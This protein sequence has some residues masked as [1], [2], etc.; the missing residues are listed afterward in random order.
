MLTLE[1]KSENSDHV[2]YYGDGHRL[3]KMSF[4][5]ATNETELPYI[6]TAN[7]SIHKG[8]KL[9]YCESN[10]FFTRSMNMNTLKQ[11][12][13][14][15][16]VLICGRINNV[17]YMV[18][19]GFIAKAVGFGRGH[20]SNTE[21][22]I[23]FCVTDNVNRRA[24]S[25]HDLK[26]YIDR[27]LYEPEHKRIMSVLKPYMAEHKGDILVTKSINNHLA[28]KY[29]LPV[30]SD[31]RSR[32][33][34]G[35]LMKE[36]FYRSI[37]WTEWN[38]K[39]QIR[40]EEE[41][42]IRAAKEAKEKYQRETQAAILAALTRIEAPEVPVIEPEVVQLEDFQP[43]VVELV[44]QV[45]QTR[46][47]IH[48]QMGIPQERMGEPLATPPEEESDEMRQWLGLDRVRVRNR[49]REEEAERWAEQQIAELERSRSQ[50]SM[51][52]Q[53]TTEQSIQDMQVTQDL[54]AFQQEDLR[55]QSIYLGLTPTPAS[56]DNQPSVQSTSTTQPQESTPE[57]VSEQR[58]ADFDHLFTLPSDPEVPTIEL[59]PERPFDE[60]PGPRRRSIVRETTS[61]STTPTTTLDAS[62]IPM[63]EDEMTRVMARFAM[64]PDEPDEVAYADTLNPITGESVNN[65]EVMEAAV[66]AVN[67]VMDQTPPTTRIFDDEEVQLEVN[68]DD[69]IIL[70]DGLEADQIAVDEMSEE[71]LDNDPNAYTDAEV[72]EVPT[73]EEVARSVRESQF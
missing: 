21:L 1:F 57:S 42:K 34:F 5:F 62:V 72:V 48:S 40:L 46:E 54:L 45:E 67:A 39:E 44:N 10:N 33:E 53:R 55:R 50:Q 61:I 69:E 7:P 71:D 68:E 18:G 56:Q 26:I 70:V 27:E 31:I 60:V 28:Y 11:I 43:G 66:A 30:L 22:K 24:T 52:L 64:T 20:L 9:H 73:V 3:I 15:S 38:R 8:G 4:R 59:D 49:Q 19:K 2:V 41:E 17:Y 36:L 16:P 65:T 12:V 32:A 29:Q 13:E 58:A 47:E 6:M 35:D 51:E 23:L 14:D 25:P 63:D 37:Y